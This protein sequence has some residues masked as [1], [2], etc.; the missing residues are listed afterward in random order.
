MTDGSMQ[1][2]L[3]TRDAESPWWRSAVVYQVY[4]RSFADGE[5]GRAHV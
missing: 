5:I 2:E 1:V 3:S 4:I